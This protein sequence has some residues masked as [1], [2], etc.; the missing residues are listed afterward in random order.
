MRRAFTLIEL[1]VVIAIIG[2]LAALLMPALGRARE[3]GRATACLSNL[4]QVGLALQMYVQDNHNRLPAMSD[5]YPGVI[6]EHP[7]PNQVLG[8]YLGNTNV[9]RCPSDRFTDEAAAVKTLGMTFFAQTG[10][11]FAW[12]TL[13]NG[14]NPEAN[15]LCF[16]ILGLD[17]PIDQIPLFSDKEDFHRLRGA[18]N[19]RNYVYWDVRVSKQTPTVTPKNLP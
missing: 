9:L 15:N 14:Q 18:G 8:D 17:F 3:S 5:L 11:S 1:L 12:N 13:I 7:G 10:S 6:N 16:R 2:T 4:R 19:A